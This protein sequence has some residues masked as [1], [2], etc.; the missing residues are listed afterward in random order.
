MEPFFLFL[1]VPVPGVG[2]TPLPVTTAPCPSLLTGG[3]VAATEGVTATKSMV[4][5][6]MFC[7]ISEKERFTK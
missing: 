6:K 5:A 7:K 2:E 1:T 3:P 4:G